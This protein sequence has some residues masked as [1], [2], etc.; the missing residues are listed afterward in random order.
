MPALARANSS[1]GSS[2]SPDA[3]K[4]RH[5]YRKGLDACAAPLADRVQAAFIE[6]FVHL[7]DVLRAAYTRRDVALGHVVLWTW[8]L[9]FETQVRPCLQLCAAGSMRLTMWLCLCCG[10]GCGCGA[11]NVAVAQDHEFLL[12]VGLLPTLQSMFS[13]TEHAKSSVAQAMATPA[14]RAP[15]SPA[16]NVGA[17]A[18][19]AAAF[20]SPAA[21]LRLGGGMAAAV[22]T[23]VRVGGSLLDDDEADA[24]A[25]LEATLLVPWQ[26][27]PLHY[28]R[29]ALRTGS[30]TKR[31]LL[32]HVKSAP[33][34]TVSPDFARANRLDQRTRLL[35]AQHTLSSALALYE[36]FLAE[37][38]RVAA[39]GDGVGADDPARDVEASPSTTAF[40]AT[41]IQTA[42][43]GFAV[44]STLKCVVKLRWCRGLAWGALTHTWLA[45]LG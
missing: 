43:R 28:V 33:A 12:R 24:A 17:A 39:G 10:C 5:H 7:A 38:R 44:R 8:G 40:A 9:D 3:T 34:G 36:A 26:P 31:E 45:W 35:A 42:F 20:S 19:A 41:L 4:I 11:V 16:A 21:T 29:S 30:L 22:G 2:S 13:L 6:L 32:L 18:A 14:K 27:W 25:A 37:S 23:P 15:R 1:P